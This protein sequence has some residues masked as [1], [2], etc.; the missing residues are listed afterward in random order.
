MDQLHVGALTMRTAC[1]NLLREVAKNSKDPA[2]RMMTA[3]YAEA[4][5][6]LP[7]PPPLP[8]DA[9]ITPALGVVGRLLHRGDG[10]MVCRVTLEPGA[11]WPE[12]THADETEAVTVITGRVSIEGADWAS[13][14]DG[15]VATVD[16]RY[17]LGIQSA[18]VGAGAAHRI[19]NSGAT[20]AEYISV[21]RRA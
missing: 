15:T 14:G 6:C 10:V 12:E 1:A 3:A 17:V 5:E 11:S 4:I 20:Q 7:L 19:V 16:D 2:A 13:F 21:L 18:F 9:T 8:D